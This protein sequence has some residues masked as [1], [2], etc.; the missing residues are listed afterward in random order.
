[1]TSNKYADLDQKTPSIAAT[2]SPDIIPSTEHTAPIIPHITYTV[3][4]ESDGLVRLYDGITVQRDEAFLVNRKDLFGKT[5]EQIQ[6]HFALSFLPRFLC[7]AT[8][9][10][11]HQVMAGKLTNAAG[12]RV[13]IFKALTALNLANERPLM[14]ANIPAVS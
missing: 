11:G 2:A 8:V 12:Q 4:M 14:P 6:A 9:P 13:F 3:D 10:I 5:S 7:D 1:M